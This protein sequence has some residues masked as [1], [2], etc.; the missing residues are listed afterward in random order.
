MTIE[1]T[2]TL[3]LKLTKDN[4]DNW[5][6]ILKAFLGSQKYIEIVTTEKST[7]N[8]PKVNQRQL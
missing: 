1:N 6:I 7:N 4:Y 2:Q 5:C 3:I 8:H